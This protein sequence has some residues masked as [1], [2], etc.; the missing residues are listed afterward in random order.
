MKRVQ[1]KLE[2]ESDIYFYFVIP[3]KLYSSYKKQKYSTTDDK[4]TLNM[5]P[6]IGKHFKQYVL[7]IDLNF[8]LPAESSSTSSITETSTSST[9]NI[10]CNCKGTCKNNICECKHKNSLCEVGCYLKNKN[11]RIINY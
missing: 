5:G 3:T 1:S 11:V 8:A 10:K 6:W 9:L 4:D 2:T 7:K